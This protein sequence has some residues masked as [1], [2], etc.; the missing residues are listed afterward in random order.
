ML[1]I[2]LI[3]MITIYRA[4]D[5]NVYH[6]WSPWFSKQVVHDYIVCYM[7]CTISC[8]FHGIYVQTMKCWSGCWVETHALE[9]NINRGLYSPFTTYRIYTHSY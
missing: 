2:S 3:P 6:I 8:S 4:E 5:A 9:H 7:D 1:Q